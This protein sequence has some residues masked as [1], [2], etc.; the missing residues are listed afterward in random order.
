M[1]SEMRQA[2]PEPPEQVQA[3]MRATIGQLVAFWAS[4]QSTEAVKAIADPQF[5]MAGMFR[6]M[7]GSLN[8]GRMDATEYMDAVL[9]NLLHTYYRAKSQVGST[10]KQVGSA[11]SHV[12]ELIVPTPETVIDD[13]VSIAGMFQEVARQFPGTTEEKAEQYMVGRL[14]QVAEESADIEDEIGGK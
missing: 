7:G 11:A 9:A 3:A 10:A 1:F 2:M 14:Q 6:E 12:P 5:G 8:Q 13:D 4:L